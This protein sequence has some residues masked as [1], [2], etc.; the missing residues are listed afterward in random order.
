MLWFSTLLDAAMHREWIFRLGRLN[1]LGRVAHFISETNCRLVA[2]GMSDGRAF[3]LP[4]TQTDICEACGLTNIHVSR[5]L[6]ELR[7][8]GAATMTDQVVEILDTASLH[9]LGEFDAKY[10]YFDDGIFVP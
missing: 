10:L 4:L 1:A 8:R 2:T 7:D 6:R 5:M 3:R 9:A